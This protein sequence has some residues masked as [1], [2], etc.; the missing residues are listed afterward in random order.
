M[1]EKIRNIRRELL[2]DNWYVLHQY[3]FDYKRPDGQWEQQSREVYDRGN[4]AAILLM[5]RKKGSVILTRQ[6]RIPTFLN[7]NQDG[8]MVEVPAGLLD[9]MS[10]EECIIKE[11]E[12]ETGYR[13][14]E[15]KKVMETYMSP[16]AVTEVLH[17]FT[18]FYDETMKVAEGGGSDEETEHIEVIEIPFSEA[19]GMIDR[20]SLKDAKSILLLQ[21]AALHKLME[22]EPLIDRP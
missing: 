2:S 15:V 5:N 4:G 21:H 17:L 16:G 8:M 7:G 1:S 12:E 14:P 20:G 13:I 9:G 10:P 19:L 6:F 3:S 22:P 11:V 18:G